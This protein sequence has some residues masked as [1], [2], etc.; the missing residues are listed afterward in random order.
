M[1]RSVVRPDRS[2]VPNN[3]RSTIPTK[4][5]INQMVNEGREIITVPLAQR[6]LQRIQKLPDQETI[7]KREELEIEA[8]Y[9]N[10]PVDEDTQ[11]VMQIK[12][13]WQDKMCQFEKMK[14][15]LDQRQKG[16]M[17]LYATLR[18]THKMMVTLG[19]QAELPSAEDLRVMNVAKL[20]PDQ[21]LQLCSGTR[22]LEE[23][24]ST[25]GPVTIDMNKLYD[26]PTKL[27]ATCEQT[28]IKRKEIIDWF[29]TLKTEDKGISMS[30]LT[31]K[32][33][34]FNA[35]NEMLNCSLQTCKTEFLREL[36]E[37]VDYLRRGVNET[38]ALQLRTEELMYELSDLNSQ[39]VDLKKQL[40]ASEHLKSQT[41]RHRLE[42]LEKEL[43][44]E[45][46]KK[47][48]FKERLTRAEGQVKI[49]NERAAQLE[50][51]LELSRSQN[52]TLE[53]TVQQLHEQNQKLQIDFDK[54]LNKLTESIRD[55]TVHLEQIA[56][57]R[58]KLQTEKEDLEKRLQDL[59]KCYDDSL[60]NMKKELNANISKLTETEKKFDEEKE[61]RKK[62]ESKLECL[63][64]QLLESELRYKDALKQLQEQ[65]AQ[66]TKALS[67]KTE[68]E[69]TKRDLEMAHMEVDNYR[70]RLLKQNEAVKEI[71]HNFKET[72]NTER[73][74]K[75][76]LKTK[77][78]Y[79]SELEK[80]QS[81]LEEQLQESETKMESYENQL[82]S[83]KTHIS[84]LQE[85]FGEF[86]NLN[87]LHDMLN[88]QRTKLAEATRQNSE[89]ADALAKKE[90][91]IE[92]Q[93]EHLA[94]QEG[95]LEQREGVIKMY[96][97]KEEEQSNIIKLLRT[98]LEIRTQA[99]ADLS[100]QL[101]EK[102][103]EIESLITNLETRK[104]QIS[105][106][107]KIILTLEEQLRKVHLQRRKDQE[108]MSLLEK[109]ITDYE[110]YHIDAKR[111]IEEPVDNLDNLIKILE[112]ELGTSFDH[113]PEY[114]KPL[115]KKKYDDRRKHEKME[116]MNQD[117]RNVS[118]YP[119]EQDNMPSKII[120][121]N[122]GKTYNIPPS[123]D[124]DIDRKKGAANIETQKWQSSPEHPITLTPTPHKD[125]TPYRGIIPVVHQ[126]AE[127]YL[128]RN[129]QFL[130][131]NQ[132]DD[133][134][135]KMFKFAGH[136]L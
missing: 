31:K 78:E 71:E 80:K 84:Q 19:Q 83:L 106:L 120:V 5:A 64:S 46:C 119:T 28:L 8:D 47:M 93:L 76:E 6:Q 67:I 53:R 81:L 134:K 55:N 89:L 2:P 133:K 131:T 105:Q 73:N 50:A 34:E 56:E 35:E 130:M 12:M 107:E 112:D 17:E 16:I 38:M 99:D 1:P 65:D 58:E 13:S 61:E 14:I 23:I 43:K 36:N 85:D 79:I 4:R 15:E 122:Y 113:K 51:A 7:K 57:A 108:K 96:T 32:I 49:G 33:N 77:D 82:A 136:R 21:L 27:V 59:T 101:I 125:I 45:K 41:N 87:Q 94:E 91:E 102:N 126:T 52:W 54:E 129:L 110:S 24:Q 124:R 116:G 103:S 100:Q 30:K 92:S 68:W 95:L 70:T 114:N 97:E 44:D 135:S 39:N 48:V 104:Q 37:I 118:L 111:S 20:S 62:L 109:A 127:Q 63:C 72:L 66:L 123:D 18:N 117:I 132:R 25:K 115:Q 40:H 75:A 11:S 128:S 42:E 86:E 3:R 10:I 90:V 74:L 88:Q 29:E 26:M 121:G 9:S 22:P 69:A 98:N 60:G